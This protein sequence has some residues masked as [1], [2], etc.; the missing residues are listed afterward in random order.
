MAQVRGDAAAQALLEIDREVRDLASGRRP[1][2]ADELDREKQGAVLAL[3]GRFATPQAAL[4]QYRALVYYGLPLD[5][6]ATYAENVAA[7]TREHVDRAAARE[8][9]PERAVYLVVGDGSLRAPLAEIAA[10]GDVGDG[11]FVELDADGV[12]VELPQ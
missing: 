5:Y 8:L 4:G 3:P 11:G 2:T 6:Y 1:V 12:P 9:S 7:V 10:R